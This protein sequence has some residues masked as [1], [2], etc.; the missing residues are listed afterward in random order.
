[1]NLNHTKHEMKNYLIN[2]FKL[3]RLLSVK[4]SQKVEETLPVILI[5]GLAHYLLYQLTRDE[6]MVNN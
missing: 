4:Q 6:Y 1:M 3:S 5:W 2:I